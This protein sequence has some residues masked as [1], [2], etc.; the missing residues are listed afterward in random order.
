[1]SES[2]LAAESSI[3]VREDSF[4]NLLQNTSSSA[5]KQS[6]FSQTVLQFLHESMCLQQEISRISQAELPSVPSLEA[7]QEVDWTEVSTLARDGDCAEMDFGR[8]EKSD[9]I[10]VFQD[11]LRQG[12]LYRREI[13]DLKAEL[14][15]AKDTAK[16]K[17]STVDL[18][19]SQLQAATKE[20]QSLHRLVTS[21]QD[22]VR[23]AAVQTQESSWRDRLEGLIGR[24]IEENVQLQAAVRVQ[25]STLPALEAIFHVSG[26][27]EVV[28][29]AQ[30]AAEVLKTLPTVQ[31]YVH[32][33]LQILL[34]KA[35]IHLDKAGLKTALQRLKDLKRSDPRQVTQKPI[36]PG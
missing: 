5:P 23:S 31:R 33:T 3:E 30:S 28:K 22:Q 19:T 17:S 10:E 15:T 8:M 26:N 34:G 29:V 13:Q 32:K 25:A 4:P 2:S 18:L 6:G 9:W 1:M 35:P 21:L 7:S 20:V 16:A 36:G 24:L 14:E 27:E 12:R 11:L